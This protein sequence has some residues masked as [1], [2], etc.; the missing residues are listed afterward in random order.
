MHKNS[1]KINGNPLK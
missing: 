1:P